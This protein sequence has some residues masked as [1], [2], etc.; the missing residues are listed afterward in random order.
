MRNML[1][2][3]GGT[4]TVIH[5]VSE[6]QTGYKGIIDEVLEGKNVLLARRSEPLVM[7]VDFES[8]RETLARAAQTDELSLKL[9]LLQAKLDLALAGGP[10]LRE[11]RQ[12][13][14]ANPGLTVAETRAELKRRRAGTETV[15][16]EQ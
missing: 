14:R 1:T 6:L 4:P 8:F 5:K 13:A 12:R 7:M 10:T 16:E 11:A 2:L 15:A 9:E 3:E